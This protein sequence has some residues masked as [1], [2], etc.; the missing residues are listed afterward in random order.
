MPCKRTRHQ[1]VYWLCVV[2]G[3]CCSLHYGSTA[4]EPKDALAAPKPSLVWT[5]AGDAAA[6][7][8][9]GGGDVPPTAATAAGV[10]ATAA[11][12][13]PAAAHSSVS[14]HPQHPLAGTPPPHTA[15]AAA[16]AA[17]AVAHVTCPPNCPSLLGAAAAA[18]AAHCSCC[19]HCCCSHLGVV[20]GLFAS[21]VGVE[22]AP[23]VFNLDLK[24]LHGTGLR[25]G[26]GGTKEG[27]GTPPFHNM[28]VCVGWG[29]GGVGG[30]Q[31]AADELSYAA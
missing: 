19:C 16:A 24:V 25:G 18:A 15:V 30:P 14:Q 20:A 6:A 5:A 26:R 23:H 1:Q 7:A 4:K 27:G 12:A 11:T 9:A 28:C 8:A 10:A 2:C 31:H 13:P 21:C 22:A 17:A 3:Y 29:G